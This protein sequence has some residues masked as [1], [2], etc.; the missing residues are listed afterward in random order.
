MKDWEEHMTDFVPD[1]LISFELPP[2]EIEV[3]NNIIQVLE[4]KVSTQTMVRGA[5]FI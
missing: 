5:Y 4:E 1:D 2:G 3:Q